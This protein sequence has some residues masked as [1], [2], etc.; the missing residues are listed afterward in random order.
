M[1]LKQVT[2][3][4]KVP[5]IH[6]CANS[7]PHDII[8]ILSIAKIICINIFYSITL[9]HWNPNGFHDDVIKWKHFPR[10][11]PFVRGIHR[12][13]VNSPHKGQWRTALMFSLICTWINGGVKDGDADDL[14]RYHTHYDV[15]VMFEPS[16]WN[17]GNS[18]SHLIQ[19]NG[20]IK[21]V[22]RSPRQ[23]GEI[24]A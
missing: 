13:P 23:A 16:K 24:I 15:I 5:W 12:W 19:L 9:S 3:Y 14:R 20:Y 2:V 22:H 7:Y 21:S 1:V 8:F 11:W 17:E 6:I 4:Y 10:Y 18:I